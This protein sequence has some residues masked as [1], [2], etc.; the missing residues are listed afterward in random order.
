MPSFTGGN[1]RRKWT[2]DEVK[3]VERHMFD[4]ITSHKVPGK[5]SCDACLH[6]EPVALKDRDWLSIKNYIHNRITTLK[7]KMNI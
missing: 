1:K 5:T 2:G 3:A 6:A 4:F 7:R